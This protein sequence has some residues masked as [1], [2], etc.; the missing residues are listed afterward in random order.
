MISN[1]TKTGNRACVVNSLDL[2]TSK[3]G[4][5]KDIFR[6]YSKFNDISTPVV[7]KKKPNSHLPSLCG[8]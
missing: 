3:F 4:L 8:Q 6:G 7:Q 1:D 5:V 2:N